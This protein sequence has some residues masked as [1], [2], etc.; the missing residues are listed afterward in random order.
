MD[1]D[2]RMRNDPLLY[3][4]LRHLAIFYFNCNID[5]KHN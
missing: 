1:L 3:D 2:E 4:R 5:V